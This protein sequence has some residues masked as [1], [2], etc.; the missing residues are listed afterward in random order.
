MGH[1]F[2]F[3]KT[4]REKRFKFILPKP[5]PF[6]GILKTPTLVDKGKFKVR[7]PRMAGEIKMILKMLLRN[8]V[9]LMPFI[10]GP[11]VR[12]SS[13]KLSG[14][15]TDILNPASFTSKKINDIS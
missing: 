4:I 7:K 3:I 10:T 5:L 11:I 9:S 13:P 15:A 14:T 2:T 1:N 8:N 6:T 12:K